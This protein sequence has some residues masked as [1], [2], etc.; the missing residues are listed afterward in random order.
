MKVDK[1]IRDWLLD[2]QSNNKI[3]LEGNI[4]KI[5][6]SDTKDEEFTKYLEDANNKD[7]EIRK[8][9]LDVTKQIQEQNKNLLTA[10]EENVKINEDLK[11]ALESAEDEK[12]KAEL[13]K[14]EAIKAKDDALNDLDILQK[15]SETELIGTII[16]VA[17]IVI[18][19]VGVITTLMYGIAMFTGKDTQIIGSTWSNMLGILLTNAFSIVGTIMG[20]KY[21]TEKKSDD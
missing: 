17:L 15:K 12:K 11:M 2:I 13:S 6:E 19:G 14:I 21:A 7:K 8:K 9:R 10:Q 20:V 4:L 16:K 5:I 1:K 18:M 3:F